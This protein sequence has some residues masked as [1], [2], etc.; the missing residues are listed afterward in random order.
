MTKRSRTTMP[1]LLCN[2]RDNDNRDSLS[3]SEFA[4]SREA[5]FRR[6]TTIEGVW[7]TPARVRNN[8]KKR[9]EDEV[10]YAIKS[11]GNKCIVEGS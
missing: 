2:S 1:P 7:Q 4:D 8:N 11:R 6:G 10:S 3:A 9:Q 5:P